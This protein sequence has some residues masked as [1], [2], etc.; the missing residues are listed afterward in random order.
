MG[1]FLPA[2]RWILRGV[3]IMVALWVSTSYYGYQEAWALTL[4]MPA[5]GAVLR[6]GEMV[7][8]S[9]EV[10][11]EINLR[12]VKYY[13]YRADEEPLASHQA[14][15]APFRPA[16]AGFPFSGTVGIP[17]DALGTMRLLAVGEVT[18]G[19][20]AGYEDFDEVLVTVE[21]AAALTSIEF[22]V[23]KPWRL[24]TIGQR[25]V[26]PAVGQ[27]SDGVLR[28]L[29]SPKAG[30]TYRSSDESVVQINAAGIVQVMGNGKARIT[31]EYRGRSGVV[32]VHVDAD[33]DAAENHAPIARIAAELNVKTGSLVV[34]NGLGSSDPDGDPLRYSWKQIRGHRVTLN[35]VNEA[36]TTF[37]AP[38]V[39]EPK[40]FQFAL[41]VMDMA[42]PD[43]VKGA[44]SPPAII[45]V[46]VSP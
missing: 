26:V 6:S 38:P 33:A 18:R 3:V 35:S 32:E 28:P 36:K 1:H 42:G 8:V 40:S 15:P 14:E 12:S 9:V 2:A 10:G 4:S 31:V 21:P 17:A 41:T 7:P 22:A 39:S 46:L 23:E 24:D 19:R 45:T 13:W 20:L 44:E 27:F 43:R 5:E 34:L 29:T 11:K 25:V 37:V 16:E 30:S